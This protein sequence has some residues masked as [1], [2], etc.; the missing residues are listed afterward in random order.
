MKIEGEC[1][2]K[3]GKYSMT[4]CYHWMV[5]VNS[6]E[7]AVIS[8][9]FWLMHFIYF[10]KAKWHSRLW[11]ICGYLLSNVQDYSI[12]SFFYSFRLKI[13]IGVMNTENGISENVCTNPSIGSSQKMRFDGNMLLIVTLFHVCHYLLKHNSLKII[14]SFFLTFGFG[15]L[16]LDT[17]KNWIWF[18]WHHLS[19]MWLCMRHKLIHF[20]HSRQKY[21]VSI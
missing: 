15:P 14:L 10:Y 7:T 13:G 9:L 4:R 1:I 6:M 18:V 21:F 11:F 20:T 19:R 3:Q 12:R 16:C 2:L 5:A 8:N 17:C